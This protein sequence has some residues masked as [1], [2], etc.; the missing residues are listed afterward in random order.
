MYLIQCISYKK[1]NSKLSN[2]SFLML[3]LYEV[4]YINSFTV[5]ICFHA[6][7]NS[8]FLLPDFRLS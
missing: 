1:L 4:T 2:F 5:L 3:L 6:S 8:L 7:F